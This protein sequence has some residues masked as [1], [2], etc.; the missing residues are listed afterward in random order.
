MSPALLGRDEE[1]AFLGDVF[2]FQERAVYFPRKPFRP[3]HVNCQIGN[4]IFPCSCFCA[5]MEEK[6][7]EKG[8]P[9]E[10]KSLLFSSSESGYK[11]RRR[12]GAER[13]DK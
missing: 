6:M 8:F 1:I 13:E 4:R 11:A 9:S 10:G 3:F 7:L 2:I 12:S 5:V